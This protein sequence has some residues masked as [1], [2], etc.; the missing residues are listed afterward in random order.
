MAIYGNFQAEKARLLG[1]QLVKCTNRPGYC[2]TEEEILDYFRG[3]YLIL[4]YNEIR[5]DQKF[6]GDE[7]IKAR[8]HMAW[9]PINTQVRQTLPFKVSTTQLFLQDLTINLDE[10]TEFNDGTLFKL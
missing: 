10:L 9:L 3:K 6:Y 5:F 4:L 7:S 2:K 1:V 8:S